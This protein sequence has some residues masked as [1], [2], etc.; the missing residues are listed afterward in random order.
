MRPLLI[1][2]VALLA[3]G[4]ANIDIKPT[5]T[6]YV[7][8]PVTKV[9]RQPQ[10]VKV[11]RVVERVDIPSGYM[12]SEQCDKLGRDTGYRDVVN[13][14]GWPAGDNG[15][16]SYAGQLYYPL[17]DHRTRICTVDFWRNRVDSTKIEENVY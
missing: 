16:D 5:R 14:Y 9:I 11:V 10:K 3:V 2:A 7:K 15:S 6:K 4:I 8:V 17:S 1:A 12:T 13:L